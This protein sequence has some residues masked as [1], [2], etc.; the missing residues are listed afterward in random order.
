MKK[1][2][3]SI[4]LAV[5]LATVVFSCKKKEAAVAVIEAPVP[6][7]VMETPTAEVKTKEVDAAV[8]QK[9]NE[10]IKDI[11]GVKAESINGVLTITGAVSSKDSR[12]LKMSVDALKL[13]KVDFKQTLK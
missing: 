8:L 4:F 9:V 13:E 2:V 5:A 3:S 7:V 12:K 6:A 11:P 1:T 10:A